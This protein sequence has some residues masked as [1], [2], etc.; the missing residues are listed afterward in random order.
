MSYITIIFKDGTKK[1]FK[2]TGRA[3]GS[4]TKT[5][6]LENGFAIIEDEWYARTIFPSELIQEIQ[7]S[8]DRSY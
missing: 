6:K 2:P 8:P 5:L 3:G 4:Y 1:E 7:T